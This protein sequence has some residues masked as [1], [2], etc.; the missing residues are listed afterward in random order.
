MDPNF[1][2]AHAH[3]GRVYAAKGMYDKAL[4]QFE[5]IR[6]VDSEYFNLDV[7]LGYTYA[8]AGR[9]EESQRILDQLIA[10]SD[11]PTGQAF[12]IGLVYAGLDNHDEAFAWF[13]KAAENREFGMI[14]INVQI[15][16]DALRQDPRFDNLRK[17]I[18]L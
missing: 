1:S 5:I 8:R 17:K 3:L 12:E 2:P 10:R 16:L 7:M 15:W 4:A 18:G 6:S 13:E 11:T 14:L 9:R